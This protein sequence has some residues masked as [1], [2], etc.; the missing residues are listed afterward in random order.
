MVMVEE[1]GDGSIDVL[2]QIGH[3]RFRTTLQWETLWKDLDAFQGKKTKAN[4]L[5]AW[6]RD[7]MAWASLMVM[8]ATA[9]QDAHRAC[10]AAVW[11]LFRR[12]EEMHEDYA[13]CHLLHEIIEDYGAARIVILC[14]EVADL[15]SFLWQITNPTITDDDP[16]LELTPRSIGTGIYPI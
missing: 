8:S 4:C 12:P 7:G 3:E 16:A 1:M 13:G 2:L 10:L 5:K 11:M 9:Y 14:D 6:T 15:R